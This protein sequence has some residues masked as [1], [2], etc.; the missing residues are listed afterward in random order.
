MNRRKRELVIAPFKMAK[1]DNEVENEGKICYDKE[2]I[3]V[4]V[5]N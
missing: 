3:F 4:G 2:E 5:A 1:F